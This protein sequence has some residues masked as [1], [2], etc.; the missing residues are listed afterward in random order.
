M[1]NT[2]LETALRTS[3]FETIHLFRGQ[4]SSKSWFGLLKAPTYRDVGSFKGLVRLV[5]SENVAPLV[6]DEFFQPKPYV[7]RCADMM[8][9]W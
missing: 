4:V 9:C 3:P 5:R 6:P 7:I 1:L 2:D 8:I